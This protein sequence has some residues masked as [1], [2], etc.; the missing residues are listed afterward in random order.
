MN[1][2]QPRQ[3]PSRAQSLKTGNKTDCNNLTISITE[4][5]DPDIIP[6]DETNDDPLVISNINPREND[7]SLRE[8]KS[9]IASEE[10]N[11]M[12]KNTYLILDLPVKDPGEDYSNSDE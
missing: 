5:W 1:S 9:L 7:S 3:L 10:P 2:S 4:I 12:E 6:T 8:K 11:P